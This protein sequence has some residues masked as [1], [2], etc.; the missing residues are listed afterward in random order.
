MQNNDFT[1]VSYFEVSEHH[2]GQR[3]DNY[4]IRV[5]KGV[6]RSHVYKLIR[7]HE[8]RVNKKRIG[9]D[10]K[11]IIGDVIR[12]APVRYAVTTAP[13]T[14]EQGFASSLQ[15]RIIHRQDGLIVFNKPA[16]MAVHGGSGVSLGV[17]EALRAAMQLPHLELVHRID[18]DTSGVLLIAEK[19]SV[20]KALQQQFKER[21]VDKTYIAIVAGNVLKN[22]QKIDLPLHRLE[23]PTG[24]RQVRVDPAQGKPSQTDITV[25]KRLKG[26]TLIEAK[27]LT[28]RT[29]QIR[30]HCQAIGHPLLGDDKY[31]G[32][33]FATPVRRLCLHASSIDLGGMGSFTVPLADDMQQLI[34]ALS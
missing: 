3:I 17:I 14:V 15:Q 34:K 29:H 27:P 11:L 31:N 7:S 2:E 32:R 21:T 30:V 8:V 20:L 9:A 12:V 6:P 1:Q 28:G 22:Q 23:L 10:Y 26:A 13:A 24:E 16:G 5:L 4:L 25:S 19:N 33:K 18:R